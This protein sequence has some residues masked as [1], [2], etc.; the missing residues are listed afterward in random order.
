MKVE[1]QLRTER[2]HAWAEAVEEWDEVFVSD[3]KHERGPE[4]VRAYFRLFSEHH[5]YQDRG[6]QVPLQLVGQ[7]QT[8]GRRVQTDPEEAR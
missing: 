8:A 6:E 5:A 1:I 4:P 3:L 2:Q 7:M